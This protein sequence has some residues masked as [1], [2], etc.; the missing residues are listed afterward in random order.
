[1][2]G[3]FKSKK[4]KLFDR[5]REV[6]DG[7]TLAGAALGYLRQHG[8][9]QDQKEFEDIYLAYEASTSQLMDAGVR[10]DGKALMHEMFNDA[11]NEPDLIEIMNV[12]KVNEIKGEL[13]R[14]RDLAKQTIDRRG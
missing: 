7:C 9:K 13:E 1:M 8:S 6:I 2:F 12:V 4:Q 14:N 3:L 11:S 5:Y 10:E